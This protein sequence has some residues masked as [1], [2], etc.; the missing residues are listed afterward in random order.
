MALASM[1]LPVP[2]G[3]IK[4]HTLRQR[5][6]ILD[7]RSCFVC[8]CAHHEHVDAALTSKTNRRMQKSV[9]GA[10]IRFAYDHSSST[11]YLSLYTLIDYAT[12][13]VDASSSFANS[14]ASDVSMRAVTSKSRVLILNSLKSKVVRF[15]LLP[16]PR[17]RK[18]LPTPSHTLIHFTTSSSR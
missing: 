10:M 14:V 17:W 5:H 12:E 7:E 16:R 3:G 13:R 11:K 15:T 6:T 9:L 8:D 2:G 18:F 4:Q 1:V